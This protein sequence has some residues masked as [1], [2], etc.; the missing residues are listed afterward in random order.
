MTYRKEESAAFSRFENYNLLRNPYFKDVIECEDGICAYIFTFEKHAEDWLLFLEGKYSK[1]S[2]D[3]KNSI[4]KFVMKGVTDTRT[5]S[6]Y[7]Y[8]EQYYETYARFYSNS[9]DVAE[10][11]ELLKTVGELCDP[12]NIEKET[13][14]IKIKE[15]IDILNLNNGGE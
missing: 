4:L 2:S 13:L 7:L 1:F 9:E 15:Q 8:P 3:F 6:S 10:M 12:Y 11:I 5:L 14:N